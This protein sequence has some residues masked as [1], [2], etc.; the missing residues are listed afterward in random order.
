MHAQ[1]G[2]ELVLLRQGQLHQLGGHDTLPDHI[3]FA[4]H[5]EGQA[6]GEIG[7]LLLLAYDGHDGVVTGWTPNG[8]V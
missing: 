5:E 7:H 6:G 4:V 1:G 2:T 8:I 3:V